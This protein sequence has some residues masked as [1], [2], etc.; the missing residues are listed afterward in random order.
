LNE[1]KRQFAVKVHRLGGNTVLAVCDLDCF[2]KIL[3][4]PNGAKVKIQ[5]PF[6]GA[7]LM[8]EDDLL[9]YAKLANC[10]NFVGERSVQFALEKGI[11]NPRS[12][13]K[14]GD[15]SYLMVMKL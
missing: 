15:T 2:G 13:V 11:G 5:A 6:F 1:N 12:V 9:E 8:E 14:L 10:F 4:G 3:P 7:D